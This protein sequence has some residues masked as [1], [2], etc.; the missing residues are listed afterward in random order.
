M[1][2]SDDNGIEGLAE[3]RIIYN[4]TLTA[5]QNNEQKMI[6]LSPD[7]LQMAR[8]TCTG[9]FSIGLVV[10]KSYLGINAPPPPIP[11]QVEYLH[12]IYHVLSEGNCGGLTYSFPSS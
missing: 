11:G 2:E 7:T 3:A 6:D 9:G 10:N 12:R 5:F 1:I 4:N 8:I